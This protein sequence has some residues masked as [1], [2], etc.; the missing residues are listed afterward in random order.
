MIFGG[1]GIL[2]GKVPV[3]NAG[4]LIIFFLF[5]LVLTMIVGWP[6]LILLEWKF[7]RY[8]MRYIF[9]GW[10]CALLAWLF[11]EGAFFRVRGIKSGPA[12]IFGPNGPLNE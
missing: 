8:R 12:H 9:G 10:I 5:G 11:I 1:V 7:S 4:G 2:S 6:L 3:E